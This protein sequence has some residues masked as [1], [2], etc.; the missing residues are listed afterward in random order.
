MQVAHVWGIRCYS[1]GVTLGLFFALGFMLDASSWALTP[2]VPQTGNSISQKHAPPSSP[3]FQRALTVPPSLG[4][5]P[6]PHPGHLPHPPPMHP[7][8]LFYDPN[9]VPNQ[10]PLPLYSLPLDLG[11]PYNPTHMPT[12]R[13]F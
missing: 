11:I 6:E 12:R 3:H 2:M 10:P 7:I 9:L 4:L 8:L 13:K 1:F 5:I